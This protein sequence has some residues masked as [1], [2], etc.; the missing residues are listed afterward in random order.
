MLLLSCSVTVLAAEADSG[1]TIDVYAKYE[2]NVEGEYPA[3][4][5]DGCADVTT[6]EGMI[7]SVT[8]APENAV[9]LVIVPVPETE[10]EAWAWIESCMADTATPVH[11][12][13]IY[14]ENQD[15]NRIN[16]NGAE[17]TLYCPHCTGT[18]VVCSLDTEGNVQVLT[19]N[20]ARGVDVAFTTNGSAYYIMAEKAADPGTDPVDP[21][22]TIP[23]DPTD[24]STPQTG[25]SSHLWLWI[26]LMVVA[27]GGIVFIIVFVKKKKQDE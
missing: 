8:E 21:D 13:D 23:S 17:V 10:T 16:A 2:R 26:V 4:I 9:R 3:P 11:T 27:A 18:P 6:D 14:F 20:A 25:D 24:P 1:A 5:E 22:P 19:S 7:F 15:G 12:F